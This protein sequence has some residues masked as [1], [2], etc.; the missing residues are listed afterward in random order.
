MASQDNGTSVHLAVALQSLTLGLSPVPPAD[1]GTK[2]PLADIRVNGRWTWEPYQTIPA[3]QE[4]VLSWY[5]TGRTGNGLATGYGGLECLEFDSYNTYEA[6]LDIVADSGLEQLV[7]RI[8]CGYEEL[9]PGGGVH[10]L[11]ICDE[12]RGNTKLAERPITG[13]PHKREVLIETRGEGGFVIIA[14]SCGN[15]HPSGRGYKLVNGGLNTIETIR[16]TERESLWNLARSF[17]EIAAPII[18]R[19]RSVEHD[20]R[21]G[22]RYEADMS[23]E[24]IL[25]PMGWKKLFERGDVT[26]WTRPGKE[27]GVSATTGYCKGL[28]VF[29]TSTSFE[30]RRS[31]T[32]FGVYAHLHHAGDHSAAAR[33]LAERYANDV[34]VKQKPRART[35]KSPEMEKLT[36][37]LDEIKTSKVD[38]LYENRIAPGFI[39]LFAGRS[40]LGKSFVTC[41]IVARLSR[42]EPAIYSKIKRPPLRTLFISEDSPEY[43]LGPRLLELKA[44]RK[45]VRFMTWDAMAQYTLAD[46]EM[47]DQAY[48]ECGHPGLLVIDP[49]ANFLGSVDEHKNAEVRTVLK[50]L[51]AWLDL[52]HVAA[53]LI[54]HINKQL[55]KGMDAVERIMGSVA[56]GTTARITCAFTKDPDAPGQFLFGGTKNNLGELA[57]TFMY[58]IVKTE[59]LA[60]IEW[61]GTTD[62]TMDDAIDHIKKKSK[63]KNAVEWLEQRFREKREW[64]S[65]EIRAMGKENGITSYAL[66]ESPAEDGWPKNQP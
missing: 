51:I 47:L 63:G 18:H 20:E 2:R 9:T 62:T 19:P 21:P 13:E 24:D 39:T 3:T 5:K 22:D 45:M 56:W 6:F 15:V 50:T 36:V 64:E 48:Q 53:I 23:W 43:V 33:E 42:G 32:K 27:T 4:H 54:T 31:Y 16:S 59:T 25:E 7:D 1:D 60:T 11:Y 66:F 8:R 40:G 46:V 44:D 14:P 37:G 49:P 38:W 34:P 28:F 57:E 52:H 12:L 55:G 10:W 35:P 41:D 17:D 26:Y 65:T 30:P 29:S 61:Q 58:K